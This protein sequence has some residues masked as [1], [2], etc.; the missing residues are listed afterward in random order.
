M[1]LKIVWR[2]LMKLMLIRIIQILKVVKMKLFYPNVQQKHCVLCLT[3]YFIYR[4]LV[5]T[6]KRSGASQRM[7]RGTSFARS[8]QMVTALFL[9]W[10]TMRAYEWVG[11]H[12]LMVLIKNTG[13]SHKFL[14]KN[15]TRCSWSMMWNRRFYISSCPAGLRSIALSRSLKRVSRPVMDDL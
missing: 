10:K 1:I 11:T 6:I 9:L 8:R 7:S 4:Y 12:L 2:N 13:H 14:R 3:K 15:F 5:D